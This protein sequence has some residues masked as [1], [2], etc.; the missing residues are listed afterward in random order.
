LVLYNFLSSK[1]G[2]NSEMLMVISIWPSNEILQA[3]M[4]NI[5]EEI[6]DLSLSLFPLQANPHS[7]T[8]FP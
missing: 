7:L 4:R 8:A 3:M 2:F 1:E 6:F 5:F